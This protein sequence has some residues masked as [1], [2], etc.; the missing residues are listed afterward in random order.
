[1]IVEGR[2]TGLV[3]ALV[4]DPPRYFW[5]RDTPGGRMVDK[6]VLVKFKTVR[7]ARTL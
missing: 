2:L 7:T 6:L 1:M 5:V 3:L 4:V